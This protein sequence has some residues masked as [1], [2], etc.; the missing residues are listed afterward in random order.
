MIKHI[1]LVLALGG[2]AGY[3]NSNWAR[4]V[5]NAWVSDYLFNGALLLLLFVMGV[6]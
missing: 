6:A 5:E 3:L 2:A 4:V 1:L